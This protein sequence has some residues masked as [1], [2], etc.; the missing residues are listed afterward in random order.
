MHECY[1]DPDPS[2][3]QVPDTAQ[4][5]ILHPVDINLTVR[6]SGSA[7]MPGQTQMSVDIVVDPI[8]LRFTYQSYATFLACML[9][10]KEDADKKAKMENEAEEE[11]QK[12]ALIQARDSDSSDSDIMTALTDEPKKKVEVSFFPEQ[13]VHVLLKGMQIT[14]INDITVHE[15]PILRLNWEVIDLRLNR[16]ASIRACV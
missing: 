2:I 5:T 12:E 7:L 6:R 11:E 10:L 1:T 3:P 16:S 14:L 15:I 13:Y 9:V 4:T 8:K